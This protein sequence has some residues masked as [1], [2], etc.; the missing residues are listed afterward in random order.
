MSG[1]KNRFKQE[2]FDLDLT[3][4]TPRIIAMSYPASGLES[5]YRNPITEVSRFLKNKHNNNF[6]IINLSNRKY[7]YSKFDN[8]VKGDIKGDGIWVGR[9]PLSFFGTVVLNL[10]HNAQI[11]LARREK[12]SCCALFG[13]ERADWHCHLLLPHLFSQV[14]KCDRCAQLLC[15]SKVILINSGLQSRVWESP[16][17]VRSDTSSISTK[18]FQIRTFTLV[19][20]CSKE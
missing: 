12:R 15:P 2:D 1:Q 3:Y 9:P 10:R 4:I 7:D 18:C 6:L 17:P 8:M 11:P 19:P 20:N 16:S 5:I 14:P 13:G